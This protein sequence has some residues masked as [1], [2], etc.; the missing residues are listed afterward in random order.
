VDH[1]GHDQTVVVRDEPRDQLGVI[2][3]LLEVQLATE[4]DL[5]LVGDRVELEQLGRLGVARQQPG[6]RPQERQVHLDLLEDPRATDLDHDVASALEERTVRLRDR[7]RCK[8]SGI[9]ACEDVGT[10][11]SPD[12]R[13]D[14]GEGHRR[15]LVD[16]VAELLDVHVGQQVRPRRQELAQ[17][18]KGR[19]ELLECLAKALRRLTRRFA[20][21][22]DAD[23]RKHPAETGTAGDPRDGQ[24][25]ASP[26]HA[27]A[28]VRR[29]DPVD[30]G[31]NAGSRNAAGPGRSP[32]PRTA[33]RRPDQPL[34]RSVGST[35]SRRR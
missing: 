14:L 2:G 18:D 1:L 21:A 25:S 33:A 10:E 28:H 32:P 6:G 16:E 7:R 35:R 11:V 12:H 15:H 30:R 3:L 17:L 31:G 13:V 29:D 5:E 20:M 27:Y 23:L 9:D 19:A 34:N 26:L 22:D 4:V 24:G 8:R